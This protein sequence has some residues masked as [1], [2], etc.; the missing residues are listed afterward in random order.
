M[1]PAK[2]QKQSNEKYYISNENFYFI[3]LKLKFLMPETP[4]T[5][6]ISVNIKSKSLQIKFTKQINF[7]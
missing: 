1:A 6:T 3:S 2:I 5:L 7:N 4:Q